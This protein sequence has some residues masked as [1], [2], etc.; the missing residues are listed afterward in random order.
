MR[1]RTEPRA[2]AFAMG[3]ALFLTGCA[4]PSDDERT[5]TVAPPAAGGAWA[6]CPPGESLPIAQPLRAEVW[7]EPREEGIHRLDARTFHWVWRNYTND[8]HED[9]LTRVNPVE[10]ARDGQ[11]VLHLCTRAD[12][13]APTEVDD[14]PRTYAVG[15]R[16]SSDVAFPEGPIRVTV[17]WVAACPCDPLPRGNVTRPF[18]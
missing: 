16:I 7:G 10:L 15:L 3:L 9:R 13:S 5:A 4:T 2:A 1:A 11:G 18:E 14:E 8:L 17:N 6:E 12:V